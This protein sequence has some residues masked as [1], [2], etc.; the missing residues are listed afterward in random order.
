MVAGELA[1]LSESL[2]RVTFM[3]LCV[4]MSLKKE[5]A[6]R[7]QCIPCKSA[8]V[9]SGPELLTCLLVHDSP[10]VDSNSPSDL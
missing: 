2:Q 5:A 7:P 1:P 9:F 6:V 4:N 10:P 8:L 3:Y